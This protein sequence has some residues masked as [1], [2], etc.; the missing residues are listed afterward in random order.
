MEHG[1]GEE[2]EEK[3]SSLQGFMQTIKIKNIK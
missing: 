2:R 1:H 3:V